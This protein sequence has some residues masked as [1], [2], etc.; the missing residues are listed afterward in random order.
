LEVG[1]QYKERADGLISVIIPVLNESSTV[2]YV[3]DFAWA[4]P[5]VTEVI[6][7]DDGS[8]DGS[9][10]VARAAGAR[11]VTSTFL[12]KG[13]SMEDGLRVAG[14]DVILYLDGDLRD[15]GEDLIMRMTRPIFEDEADFVKAKFTRA[16]GRVTVLTARPL[17]DTFFPE[18]ATLGQPL[19]GIMAARRSLLGNVRF[20][21][22][23]GVDVGLLLDAAARGA[24]IAEVDI[25]HI[26]GDSPPL[27][28]LGDMAKQVTGVILDRAWRYERLSINQVRE[29]QEV[30]RRAE[31]ELSLA[32]QRLGRTERLALIDMDGVLIDGQF[33]LALAEKLD[34]ASEVN[35]FLDN[36]ALGNADRIRFIASVFTGVDKTVF[37]DTAREVP[38]MAGAADM[39]VAL[40][41]VGYRVG[42]VTDSYRVAA[43]IIRH[44]V[45]ADFSVAHLMPFQN[46]RARGELTLSPAMTHPEG[47]KE[48]EYCKLNVAKHL[49]AE[50]GIGPDRVLAVGNGDNDICLLK[51]ADTAVAFRPKSPAV[52]AAAQHVVMGSLVQIVDL[53]PSGS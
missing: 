32:I 37:E 28:V 46:G 5:Q 1:N 23:Y 8:I 47:C 24:R 9:P 11:V 14:N 30:E 16:A 6:V 3:V 31:A 7:V 49:M 48:H 18:L 33:I 22:D 40:R 4:N 20:E 15:L 21:P 36:Q 25:G 50:M 38:L 45:F 52:A 35:L 43:E 27:D 26:E 41:K 17:L 19:G 53:A 51:A 10:E 12:G 42:I 29:V 34:A 39:V 13:A 44:R 2:G